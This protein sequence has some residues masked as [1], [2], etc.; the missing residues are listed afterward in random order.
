MNKVTKSI[1]IDPQ[2]WHKA[3]V[4]EKVDKNRSM[5]DIYDFVITFNGQPKPLMRL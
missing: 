3:G 4:G 2:L 5:R 1:K